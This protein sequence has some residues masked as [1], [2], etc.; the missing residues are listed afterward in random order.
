MRFTRQDVVQTEL[1]DP[2]A[3]GVAAAQYQRHAFVRAEFI[4]HQDLAVRTADSVVFLTRGVDPLEIELLRFDVGTSAL[5]HGYRA[6]A[7]GQ[8]R[9]AHAAAPVDQLEAVA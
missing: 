6:R 1:A 7:V 9:E 8:E 4:E 5:A 2:L 3:A